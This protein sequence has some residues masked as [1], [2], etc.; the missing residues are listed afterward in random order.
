VTATDAT[1]IPADPVPSR[2][3]FVSV[4]LF[5]AADAFFFL[6]FLFAY[7]YLRA[8]NSNHS[9]HP[10]GTDPSIVLGTIVTAAVILSAAALR[11]GT[12]RGVATA[13]AGAAGLAAVA[14]ICQGVQL[15]DPG[16]SPSHSGGYGA[17]FVGF[18]AAFSAHLLGVLYW[19]E[20]LAVDGQ[21]SAA[22]RELDAA[23]ASLFMTFLAGV[24]VI[25]YVLLYLV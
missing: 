16:F 5:V 19:L 24:G 14:L 21:S 7:L 20:T 8:L 6:G 4:R 2:A 25:A 12:G 17:V 11:F 18:A 13:A 15:F 23:A 22:E 10:S 9:W 1:T 3:L